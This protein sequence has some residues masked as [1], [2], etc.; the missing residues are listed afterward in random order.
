MY[1]KWFWHCFTFLG[2]STHPKHPFEPR[3]CGNSKEVFSLWSSLTIFFVPKLNNV[4]LFYFCTVRR[5]QTG[6]FGC[7]IYRKMQ[8]IMENKISHK[9]GPKRE[10]MISFLWSKKGGQIMLARSYP[11]LAAIFP[12][13]RSRCPNT[14]FSDGYKKVHWEVALSLKRL[15]DWS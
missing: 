11:K 3:I 13:K 1:I 9:D 5:E 7:I 6:H 2:M 12:S 15:L 10:E 8:K 4:P 14:P